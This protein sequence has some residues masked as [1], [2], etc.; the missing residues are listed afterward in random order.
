MFVLGTIETAPC[1]SVNVFRHLL[2][3]KRPTTRDVC[4]CA[5]LMKEIA[6]ELSYRAP[7]LSSFCYLRSI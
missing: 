1:V 7:S 6:S 3:R 2:Q 4:V 5:V